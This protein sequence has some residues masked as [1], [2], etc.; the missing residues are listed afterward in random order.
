MVEIE[1]TDEFS[2]WYE[3]L[4]DE[5]A[6]AVNRY[7]GLIETQGVTLDYPYSSK[8]SGSKYNL[9]EWRVQSG[10]KPLRPLYVFDPRRNAVLLVG[11]DKTGDERYYERM[12]PI[13]ERIYEQYL[14]ATGQRKK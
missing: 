4:S 10:G 2:A 11:G 9:R 6:Q 7:V 3:A 5:D 8:L 14:I 13:A 1:V 12:I